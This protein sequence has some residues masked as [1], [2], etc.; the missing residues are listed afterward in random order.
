MKLMKVFLLLALD[1]FQYILQL[2][3]FVGLV[4]FAAGHKGVHPGSPVQA[5]IYNG[6]TLPTDW[7]ASRSY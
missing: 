4:L 2:L 7:Q 5:F 1:S 6:K 3:K